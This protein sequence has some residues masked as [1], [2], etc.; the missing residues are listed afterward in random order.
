MMPLE[1]TKTELLFT[2]ENYLDLLPPR[3]L[4]LIKEKHFEQERVPRTISLLK[5][6]WTLLVATYFVLQS[7]FHK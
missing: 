5:A 2:S 4:E 7:L 3:S 1:L 6:S